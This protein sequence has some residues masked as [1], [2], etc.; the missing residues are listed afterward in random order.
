MT[1]FSIGAVQGNALQATAIHGGVSI[2]AV[3]TP[4]P[5]QLPLAGHPL[6]GRDGLL[7]LVDDSLAEGGIVVLSG[8]AGVGKTA[9]AVWWA[10]RA[11]ARFP[12]GQLFVD[13]R[14]FASAAPRGVA[15]VLAAFLRALGIERPDELTAV[16]REATFRTLMA[17]RR[18]IVVLDNARSVDQVRALLPGES[19]CAVVVTSRVALPGLAVHFPVTAVEVPRLDHVASVALVAEAVGT[20]DVR[21]VDELARFCAG[22]PLALRL[23]GCRLVAG[24]RA[25]LSLDLFDLEDGST[26]ALRKVFSWSYDHLEA[27]AR[28]VF[29]LF[30]ALPGGSL[31][32]AAIR[33]ISGLPSEAAEAAVRSLRRAS[34]LVESAA[35]RYEPHDLL[36]SYARELVS[37]PVTFLDRAFDYFTAAA[38]HA[39]DLVSPGRYRPPWTLRGGV[40]DRA[41]AL[42]WVDVEL[43]NIV[44]LCAVGD[45]RLD[46]RRWRLA[47]A[48]RGYFY[49]TKRVDAWIRT[50]TAALAAAVRLGDL[51][52]EALTRNN[53][54]MALVEAGRL[55]EATE[56]Y[57]R[58][59][60]LFGQVGDSHGRCN[61]LVNLAAVLRRQGDFVAAL[62]NHQE[63]LAYY[64]D[65]GLGRNVGIT[66]RSMARVE[67][68]LGM[69][70]EAVGHAEEAISLAVSMDLYLDA[71]QAC[72]TLGL[73]LVSAE[74][75]ARAEVAHHLAVDYSRKARS[76][77]EEG[78]ALWRLGGVA[79]STGDPQGAARWW[80][81]ARDCFQAI[82][83]KEVRAVD[84]DLG[85]LEGFPAT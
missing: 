37:D 11:A 10:R 35:G 49:F 79:R 73:V 44:A 50:H 25:P 69:T 61:A 62:A 53:L 45:E 52:A 33:A 59:G 65:H 2:G 78:I 7:A 71:A 14:A 9:V 64:R 21:E 74:H 67:S 43:A 54:G 47:Y 75:Y 68:E 12:G 17:G 34:L 39:D 28:I 13:L 80:S 22:L 81:A 57:G 40:G 55:D 42:A 1:G 8:M 82:G 23:A 70:A 63:A 46:H 6:V 24:D 38:D 5:R 32:A 56:H 20:A 15:E 41:S 60:E 58:A 27:E 30:G 26:V 3:P 18:A 83:A 4:V 29:Q 77:R 51:A 36:R 48:V 16:E 72:N 76:L 31:D 84:D 19:R 85:S 66:V